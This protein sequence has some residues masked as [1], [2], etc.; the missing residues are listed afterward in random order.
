[1][2]DPVE[3]ST[4]ALAVLDSLWPTKESTPHI[5]RVLR[6]LLNRL[7]S[8]EECRTVATRNHVREV[9]PSVL[10]IGKLA[11]PERPPDNILHKVPAGTFPV[12]AGGFRM[13]RLP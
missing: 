3:W 6:P 7:P 12:A 2:T 5:Q 11:L 9:G 8:Q 1:M 10:V 4:E 13:G